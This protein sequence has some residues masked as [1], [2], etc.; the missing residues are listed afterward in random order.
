MNTALRGG[1]VGVVTGIARGIVMS[2]SRSGVEVTDGSG[3]DGKSRVGET[4]LAADG[5]GDR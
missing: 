2:A 5:V 4:V 3:L 1:G